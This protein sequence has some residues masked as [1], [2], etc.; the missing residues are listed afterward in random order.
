MYIDYTYYTD[1]FN[2]A[3]V[4]EETFKKYAKRATSVID[5]ATNYVLYGQ[6]FEQIAQ[7]LQDRVKEATAA[8]V[9]FYVVKGGYEKLDAGSDDIANVTIGSF[10][11]QEGSSNSNASSSAKR[12]SPTALEYLKH[13]GLL[14]RGIGVV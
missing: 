14:Y 6:N 1:E 11:Y 13:T 3:H 12:I 9:E 10:S 7:F 5:Q 2:G 4:D 8:Q